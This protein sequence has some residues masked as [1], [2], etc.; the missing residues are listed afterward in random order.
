MNQGP[1]VDRMGWEDKKISVFVFLSVFIFKNEGTI[2]QNFTQL[3]LLFCK[4][5]IWINIFIA[6][7]LKT[8]EHFSWIP[9]VNT[10]GFQCCQVFT[11]P[12]R[13]LNK[14]L[15]LFGENLPLFQ[16]FLKFHY[17]SAIFGLVV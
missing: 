13:Q 8:D 1:T 3:K 4:T 5:L 15:P 16:N 9:S 14:N 6:P 2:H 17:F 12:L 11:R 10:G 7:K